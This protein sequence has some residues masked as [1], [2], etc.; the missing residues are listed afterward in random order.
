MGGRTGLQE[1][2]N[3]GDL[4]EITTGKIRGYA[5]RMSQSTRFST[6][7]Q[8]QERCRGGVKVSRR[9]TIS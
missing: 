4:Q 2:F 9:G 1:S 7:H 5:R 3:R 8:R 6:L